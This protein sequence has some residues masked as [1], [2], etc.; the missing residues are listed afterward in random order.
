M[1]SNSRWTDDELDVL[2]KL[3]DVNAT[4]SEARKVLP[5]RG[6]NG[7]RD[8]CRRLGLENIHTHRIVIDH[9]ALASIIR[10]RTGK[11]PRKV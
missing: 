11:K 7:I 2:R 3:N 9:E 4:I 6:E 8:Q 10:M 1:P 5:H